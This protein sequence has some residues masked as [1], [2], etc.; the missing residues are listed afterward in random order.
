MLRPR[1]V[2]RLFAVCTV[3]AVVYVGLVTGLLLLLPAKRARTAWREACFRTWAR[4]VLWLLNGKVAVS[5][6]PPT[7]PFFLVANHLG[8]MDIL[9]L[10]SCTDA[11]FVAKSEVGGWPVVGALCRAVGTVFIDRRRHRDLRRVIPELDRLIAEGQSVVLFPEGT[12][13]PGIEVGPFRPS[14][15]E[16]PAQTGQ[17]VSFATLGYEAPSGQPPAHMILCWWGDMEFGSHVLDLFAL[18]RF[19]A[20]VRFG[21]DPIRASD[22][23]ELAEALQAAVTQRFV[24]VATAEEVP[25]WTETTSVQV[26]V[27]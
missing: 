16:G 4:S 5:G 27:S 13:T 21:A 20:H 26:G 17:P 19:T 23:R 3:T 9:V 10:A 7:P 18:P 11:V 22:R 6:T 8:Y 12:S 1:V 24:P 15:L 2:W 25:E 14:L